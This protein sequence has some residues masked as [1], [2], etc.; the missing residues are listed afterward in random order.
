MKDRKWKV[1]D[2][3]T[4]K[5]LVAKTQREISDDFNSETLSYTILISTLQKN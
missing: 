5:A 1:S 4:V 3:L 2:T